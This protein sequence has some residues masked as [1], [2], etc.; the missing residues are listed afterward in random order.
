MSLPA[1]VL[2]IL[3]FSALSHAVIIVDLDD[4]NTPPLIYT[5]TWKQVVN[6]VLNGSI[7]NYYD[8]TDSHTQTPGDSVSLTF[9]GVQLTYWADR[10]AADANINITLDGISTIVG[11]YNPVFLG[12]QVLFNV[13]GLENTTHTFTV[14]HVGAQGQYMNVDRIQYAYLPPVASN[15]SSTSTATPTHSSGSP[16]N[17]G[18][19]IAGS[20]IGGVALSLITVAAFFF[21]RRRLKKGKEY[22]NS[23][24][25][26]SDAGF[27]N[28]LFSPGTHDYAPTHTPLASETTPSLY[29]Q[30]VMADTASVY[31]QSGLHPVP[32]PAPTTH[33]SGYTGSGEHEIVAPSPRTP[34]PQYPA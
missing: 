5:G 11:A 1:L 34:P 29:T 17:L 20:V 30:P 19:V 24:V 23:G 10:D 2:G 21:L 3:L 22:K 32:R 13:S 31:A 9:T 33:W 6:E 15:S 28:R 8:G 16:T 26:G 14:T 4:R 7:S 18:G 12:Q 27:S 25:G